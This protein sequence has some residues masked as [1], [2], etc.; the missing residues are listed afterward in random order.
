MTMLRTSS[1]LVLVG[2]LGLPAVVLATV[3][4]PSGGHPR[5]FMDATR[6]AV[7][8]ANATVKGTAAQ[9]MV[10]R[11][12]ETIDQPK[13]YTDR[14]GADGDTWPG[15]AVSCAFAYRATQNASFLGQAIK[16]WNAALADDQA[17]G[18]GKGCVAG[19][20]TDWKTWAA[21]GSGSAPPVI[22]T[23]THD[24]GY[25]MRWYGPYVAL[26]YDWLH[27]AP[28]VDETLRAHTRM[29]LTNW[30][31]YYTQ[32]GYHHDEAGANYNAGY[33][34]GKVMTAIAFAGENGAD[35]DR[36]WN[37]TLD[38]VFGKLLVGD[39][40]AGAQDPVG[41]PAGV[42]VGGDWGE[43]WQYG[44]LSV[45]EYAAAARAMEE[46]GA[47]LPEM[48][49]WTNSLVV[50][51]VHATVPAGDGMFNSNGDLDAEDVYPGPSG[52]QLDAILLG[53]S[54]AEAAAWAMFEK[55]RLGARGSYVWNAVAEARTA[56]AADYRA[57]A[58][59]PLWYLAR[60][61][62]TVFARTAWEASAYW[63]VF[64]SPPQV[65]SDHH[66][67]CAGNFVFSRGA[68]H[69]IVDPS[70]YGE[71]G[72]LETNAPT[73]DSDRV[74][75]DYAPS[76]TPWS[77]AELLWARGTAGGV[78]AARG[79]YAK[80][81]IFSSNASDIAYARRDW[82]M[83]PEGEVVTIDRAA[84]K[85]S[86][87]KL[88]VN[89]HVNT[90][91]TLK[92]GGGL[93][94]GSVGGSQVAIHSVLGG[95]TPAITQPP[96][97]DDYN[98]PCGN[99]KQGRF[100]VDNYGVT[101]PGPWAVAIHVIDG[102]GADEAVPAVG[103][104]GDDNYDPAPKQNGAVIGAAIYRASKQSYVVA[105]SAPSGASGATLT[106][107]VPGASTGRHVVFDAPEQSDGQS[108]VTAAAV[109]DRCTV[110]VVAGPGLAGRPLM[111]SV[112]TAASGCTISEDTD[113]PPGVEPPGG[114]VTTAGTGG[115]GGGSGG[116]VGSGASGCGCALG[117]VPAFHGGIALVLALL[118]VCRRRPIGK[119]RRRP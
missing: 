86:S 28:G 102:L 31:D 115:N 95:G 5:L 107:S 53:P 25:P 65:V 50:R 116:N 88:Y 39:G 34:I 3:P 72:T 49:A 54:S 32:K 43:G 21:G 75:G 27:D 73:V 89:F 92:L 81:F 67:F 2:V 78:Y 51:F 35:G 22:L 77:Q 98:Y 12:Q 48:D 24:T 46:A 45:L 113:I 80:A 74:T 76:Q 112:G 111:F 57:Q 37:E 91:G 26:T 119:P 18:D 63:G 60:G 8:Q 85:D 66:H 84:T 105:S 30:V 70:N 59:A 79:D 69:L 118:L 1:L 40:L 56:T 87:H 61:T 20:S 90:A 29:C 83:L 52:N 17:L 96:V 42:L 94:S 110:T 23:V 47:A 108:T 4:A 64:S 55:Q 114:G 19:V 58:A 44:P 41:K 117:G 15:A 16:Y 99:C 97:K 103:S 68:D 36:L 11:C 100:V 104:I 62:R 106:Y 7:Y 101:I 82:V 9:A 109:G 14:G 13:Y 93:A 6:A 71:P 38:E 33:V 10:A